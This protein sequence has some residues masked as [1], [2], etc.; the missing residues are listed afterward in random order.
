VRLGTDLR[1]DSCPAR[2]PDRP[3]NRLPEYPQH[4]LGAGPLQK[5]IMGVEGRARDRFSLRRPVASNRT[6]DLHPPYSE[7][8]CGLNG[9]A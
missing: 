2:P 9:G 7:E 4:G 8:A 3:H 6:S 5:E 1:Y